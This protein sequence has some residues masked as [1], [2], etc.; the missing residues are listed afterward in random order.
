MDQDTIFRQLLGQIINLAAVSN[1]HA[2]TGNMGGLTLGP[3]YFSDRVSIDESNTKA[4]AML[5][6]SL[7][8]N[9]I[10][11]ILSAVMNVRY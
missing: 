5:L 4:Q 11:Q 3:M 6:L 7:A 2:K 9:L 1:V 8:Q 10:E